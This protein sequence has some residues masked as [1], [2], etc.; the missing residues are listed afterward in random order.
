MNGGRH[1]DGLAMGDIDTF[2]HPRPSAFDVP[3]HCCAVVKLGVCP[4]WSKSRHRQ[5]LVDVQVSVDAGTPE[6]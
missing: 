5:D 2:A 1:D 4:V 6:F 3:V